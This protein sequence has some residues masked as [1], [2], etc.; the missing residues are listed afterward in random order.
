MIYLKRMVVILGGISLTTLEKIHKSAIREFLKNGFEHASLR[1]I[2]KNAEVSTGAFYGYYAS[3]EA[4][5]HA[6]V[7]PCASFVMDKFK[8]NRGQIFSEEPDLSFKRSKIG[9]SL[10]WM[11]EYMY[12]NF[13]IFKLIFCAGDGTSYENF[14]HELVEI[15]VDFL[16]R[17]IRN[18]KD[19]GNNS[20]NF[21]RQ[22]IHMIVSG[23]FGGIAEVIIHD[24][25]KESAIV[26]VRQIQE[27]Y[28][29]GW[30]ELLEG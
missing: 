10:E 11:I 23:M 27:F 26:Y 15:E 20:I 12:D 30:A 7:E 9:D 6:L 25:P 24:M 19:S 14:L 28:E 29:A 5:F 18:L 13:D 17:F 4:L 21:D 2:V 1:T 8:E 16:D 22:L 3:K